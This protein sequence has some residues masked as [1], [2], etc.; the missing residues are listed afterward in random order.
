MQNTKIYK[1]SL[2]IA[3]FSMEFGVD[4]DMNSYCGGLG[5]LAGDTIK[6]ASDMGLNMIG[7]SLLYKDGWLR[8]QLDNQQGQIEFPDSWDYKKH[9][10]L[11]TEKFSLQILGEEVFVQIWEYTVKNNQKNQ[12]PIFF[13]D[14]DLP[15]NS[16]KFRRLNQRIYSGDKD[17]WYCQE[18][19]LGIGGALA[20]Q[21]LGFDEIDI[22]H[23][24][25][26]HAAF[27]SLFIREKYGNWEEVRKRLC[28]TTHTPLA[29]AHQKLKLE[30][31][32]EYLDKKY[33]EH[34]SPEVLEENKLD[35]TK[36]CLFAS[37][38]SNGVAYRHKQITSLMYPE[39]R[40]DYITNG[41]HHPTWVAKPFA[42]IFDQNILDWKE[43]PD[44]LRQI[45]R[46]SSQIIL[47]AHLE[48]KKNLV[49]FINLEI[50]KQD[51]FNTDLFDE[52]TFTIGFARRA[53][54]Y[55]R[56]DFIFSEFER[57]QK[58]T[59]K[60]GKIQIVF[61]GK[62]SKEDLEGKKNIQKILQFGKKSDSN[63][64]IFYIPNYNMSIGEKLTSGVDLWLN[65]PVPPLEASGTSGMKAALNGIPSLSVLDGWWPEGH[66][67]GITGWSIGEHLCEGDHCKDLEI[68]DL[69]EKLENIILPLFYENKEAWAKIMKNCIALN[70]SHFNTNRMLTE[71]LVKSYLKEKI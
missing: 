32:K 65:N 8:Q 44:Y 37:K 45:M 16:E 62:T 38:F 41:V 1:K 34:I 35:F 48:S 31:I 7:V 15:L 50:Q 11:R 33:F 51:I 69:Y 39:F 46:I 71:Y 56:A 36:L 6:S 53:V 26:S 19:L 9:L 23:L 54:P 13:L 12:L 58:I 25:E 5:I 27:L 40:I 64:K 55:K 18:I 4:K 2:R 17:I 42:E 29:G 21:I 59:Q 68:K 61:S 10:K 24:N 20:L 43:N 49:K 63:L 22:F 67:E 14:A 3:Y 70:G 28:F 52:K 66:I 30:I 60:I 47:G 57:L